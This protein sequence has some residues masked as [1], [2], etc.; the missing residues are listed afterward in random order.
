MSRQKEQA[1]DV[2]NEQEKVLKGWREY[3]R[4]RWLRLALRFLVSVPVGVLMCEKEV[5]K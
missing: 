3:P 5:R 2:L 4:H 1:E